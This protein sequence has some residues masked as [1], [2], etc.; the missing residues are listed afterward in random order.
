MKVTLDIAT[1]DLEKLLNP[2]IAEPRIQLSNMT[3]EEYENLV[4]TLNHKPLVRLS[5][6]EG[7]LEIMTN[8]PEHEMIKTLIGR[9]IEIYALEKEIDLYSCGSAT[10]K[11]E[12]QRRGLEPDES[13]CIGKRKEIPD[14]AIEV[15]ITSGSIEK[16]KIYQGLE[17]PEVLFWQGGKFTLYQ[18]INAVEGYQETSRSQYLPG[19]DFKQLEQYINPAE[20]PQMVRKYRKTIN[21]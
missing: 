2:I 4:Q 14:L 11:K 7:N 19:L 1:S 13:Y 16:L 10:Y 21:S 6:L 18:L 20:E 5:Y 17:I 9:L 8:S 15:I 3:W 12:A